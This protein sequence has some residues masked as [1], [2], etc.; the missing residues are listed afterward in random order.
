M[1]I[2]QAD[3]TNKKA[4][5]RFYKNNHYSASFMGDDACYFITED[6]ADNTNIIAGVIISY[7]QSTPFLHALVVTKE[8]R[9][10]GLS[11]LLLNHCQQQINL[12]YCFANNSLCRLYQQQGFASI[13]A[14]QLPESLKVRLLNY[15]QKSPSLQSLIWQR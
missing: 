9:G 5:K 2:I 10:K 1:Q 7:Q 8:Y 4:I 12:I 3:K 13:A 11:T 6:S 15:Q 14:N